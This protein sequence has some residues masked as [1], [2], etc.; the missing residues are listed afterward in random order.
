MTEQI[1]SECEKQLS[2]LKL[3]ANSG[4]DIAKCDEYIT[5]LKVY[6]RFQT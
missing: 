4:K 2:E 6:L 5:N 1:I 3:V